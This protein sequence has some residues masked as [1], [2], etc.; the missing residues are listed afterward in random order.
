M[1]SRHRV[2]HTAA[3]ATAVACLGLGVNAASASAPL[4]SIVGDAPML[5]RGTLAVGTVA[6]STNL[7]LTVVLAPRDPAALAAFATAVS[8]PGSREYHHY[9]T[10]REFARRFGASQRSIG[11]LRTMLR[12]SGLR[13]GGL[14]P[15]A[16]S[17]AV[18][19]SAA[20]I[21]RAFSVTLRR[22]REPGGASVFANTAPPRVPAGLR[23]VVKDVLGLSDVPVA[24]PTALARG[25]LHGD[26]T[27]PLLCPG[28][29]ASGPYTINQ[30][31]SAYGMDVLHTGGDNGAGVTIALYELEPYTAQAGDWAGYTSCFG[32]SSTSVTDV[33]V[34][35][36]ATGSG[37]GETALDL[38]VVAGLAPASSIKVYQGPDGG[39]GP[40]D[41]LQAIVDDSSVSVVSDSWGLCE[42]DSNGTLMSDEN[43]LLQ[44]AAAEHESWLIAAGDAGSYGCNANPSSPNYNRYSVDDPASQPFATGV[45]GT[46]LNAA[47]SGSTP[48]ET[49]WN[50]SG[51]GTGGG[52]SAI[53]GMPTYQT[54]SDTTTGVLSAYSSGSPCGA[55]AGS[56]C[57]EVPDVSADANPATGYI[58]YYGGWAAYGGTSAAAPLWAGVT[59]LADASNAGS[60]SPSHPLG[61]LNPSLYAIAAGA[62]HS[63]AFSDVLPP[64]N[65]NT[66]G[67]GNYPA[68][69]GY[70]MATGLGTPIASGGSGIVAQLCNA[71]AGFGTPPVVSGVSPTDANPGG[72]VTITGSGFT[73]PASVSFGSTAAT[74]VT[75]V[76]SAHITATV[77]GGTGSVYVT[78]STP[79]G[80]SPT[81]S[82]G[83]FT[84]GPVA[85][86]VSPA[87]GAT[88]SQGQVVLANYSCQAWT[89]ASPSC[90]GPVPSAAPVN[91][92]IV[93][94]HEFPVSTTDSRGVTSSAQTAYTVV[95]PPQITV[96]IPAASVTYFRGEKAR[97]SFSC[98]TTPPVTIA[99]CTGSIASGA[100]VDTAS[101]GQWHFTVAST[102]SNGVSATRTVVYTV[103]ATRP[104]FRALRQS[105]RTWTEGKHRGL[106]LPT[107]TRFSFRLDQAANVTLRFTRVVHGRIAGGRCVASASKGHS[108]T[109][110]LGAGRLAP[111]SARAGS[112]SVSFSGRTSSGLLSPGT[113]RVSITAVGAS[114]KPTVARLTFTVR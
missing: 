13:P 44:Q 20:R 27:L 110:N 67:S 42:L 100:A 103:V 104:V 23:N 24:T 73:S 105:A 31:A 53:W 108:C 72:V 111:V 95:P 93:G 89:G 17:I 25:P 40:Y 61:F 2:I 74:K 12:R 49:V 6:P 48:R 39:T 80:T 58:I 28:P 45:G 26:A 112:T 37:S 32:S 94:S 38:D 78:V 21:S 65:N 70:D 35:G 113:Y 88:Y 69:T 4:S 90:S 50:A 98:T 46:S 97:V 18:N 7:R 102:D 10:V 107:G 22:Y 11:A 77:P 52:I 1:L 62:A 5:M 91:T 92:A 85:S 30:I 14:A 41:T 114:G 57:R 63:S 3:F 60:C 76:D 29:N 9:L 83:L 101:I 56:Y 16:L 96:A 15:D 34:D 79:W 75:V 43:T 64:G 87:A 106:R 82:S 51:H 36:G 55:G 54:T 84:Y 66:S 71:P 19:G 59:A 99:T 8:T 47:A 109:R 33:E 68:L 86:V 81:G